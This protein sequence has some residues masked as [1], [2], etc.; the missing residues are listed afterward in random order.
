MA[1]NKIL[2]SGY[3]FV[4]ATRQITITEAAFAGFDIGNIRL[5]VNETQKYIICS[6]MQKDLITSIV[7]GLIT[8]SSTLPALATGDRITIEMDMG[9]VGADAVASEINAGKLAIS[10]SLN[11]K[12]QT[13]SVNDTFNTMAQQIRQITGNVTVQPVNMMPTFWHDPADVW[14]SNSDPTYTHGF[15]MLLSKAQT[16][17]KRYCWS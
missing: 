17:I 7:G 9:F 6:S 16:P 11:I 2:M 14:A 12:G 15:L 5:I 4:N 10:T 8:Y 13:S 3:S 1:R